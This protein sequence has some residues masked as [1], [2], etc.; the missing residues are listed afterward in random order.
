MNLPP[1]LGEEEEPG[2]GSD[3]EDAPEPVELLSPIMSP[4]FEGLSDLQKFAEEAS[5]SGEDVDDIFDDDLD[6]IGNIDD[7]GL[8]EVYDDEDEN[9]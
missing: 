2:S 8:P 9:I 7:A 5:G 4:R 6:G 1:T 3:E